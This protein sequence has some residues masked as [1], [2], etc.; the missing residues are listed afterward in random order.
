MV[1]SFV[2]TTALSKIKRSHIQSDKIYYEVQDN[3]MEISALAE[4]LEEEGHLFI[5]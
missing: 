4:V 1:T 5:Q 2:S 3:V